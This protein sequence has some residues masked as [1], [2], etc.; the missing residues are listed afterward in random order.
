M[1]SIIKHN[2][3]DVTANAFVLLYIFFTCCH[4]QLLL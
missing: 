1:L 3:V 4:L 2:L